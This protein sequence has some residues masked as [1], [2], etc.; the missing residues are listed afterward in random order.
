M[1]N[2]FAGVNEWLRGEWH[3]AVHRSENSNQSY[4]ELSFPHDVTAT[5]NAN[6]ESHRPGLVIADVEKNPL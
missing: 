2:D 5:A 1:M 4:N 3:N 6:F